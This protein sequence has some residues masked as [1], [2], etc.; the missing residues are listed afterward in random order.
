MLVVG[1]FFPRLIQGQKKSKKEDLESFANLTIRPGHLRAVL[2][3]RAGKGSNSL[4]SFL[5]S[6]SPDRQALSPTK[7]PAVTCIAEF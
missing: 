1:L 2:A 3:S 5:L 7:I 6:L 4:S